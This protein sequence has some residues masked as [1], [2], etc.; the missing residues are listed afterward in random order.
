MNS[1][2]IRILE[3]KRIGDLIGTP[4]LDQALKI[5]LLEHLFQV[6]RCKQLGWES[7]NQLHIHDM[8]E[9]ATTKLQ[10]VMTPDMDK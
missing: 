4:K 6:M 2:R 8:H 1:K 5:T 7:L 9:V 10:V 3:T